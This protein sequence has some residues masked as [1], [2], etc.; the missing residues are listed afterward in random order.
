MKHFPLIDSLILTSVIVCGCACPHRRAETDRSVETFAGRADGLV[1][2][3]RW[4]DAEAGGGLFLFTD[5]AVQSLAAVHTNQTA[6]G[7]GST[8]VTGTMSILVDTNAGAIVGATG[9]AVGNV[10]GAAVKQS[11]K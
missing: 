2:R 5:P 1:R 9:T 10:I 8:F 7:G 11:V 3:E 4:R 6:L